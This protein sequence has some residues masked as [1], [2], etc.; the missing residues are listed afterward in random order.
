MFGNREWADPPTRGKELVTF[1]GEQCAI[2]ILAV[3][4]NSER[5]FELLSEDDGHWFPARGTTSVHWLDDLDR[6]VQAVRWA[7]VNSRIVK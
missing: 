6:V 7:L 3:E 2:R 5:Q 1:Y 4:G